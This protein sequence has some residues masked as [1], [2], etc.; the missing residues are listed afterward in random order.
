MRDIA[1]A[2][3]MAIAMASGT[4]IAQ[5]VPDGSSADAANAASMPLQGTPEALSPSA[6]IG[7]EPRA[8]PLCSRTVTDE[9]VNAREAG[10]DHG[11]RPLA[12]WPGH[13]ASEPE[14]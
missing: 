10:R 9:C 13:L 11:N 14:Q 4:G 12:D 6:T 8:Y 2:T 3:A 1:I 7:A 5:P